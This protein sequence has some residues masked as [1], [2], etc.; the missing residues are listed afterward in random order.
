M[1]AGTLSPT[2]PGN[3]MSTTTVD[4]AATVW[5][6]GTLFALGFASVSYRNDTAGE[7]WNNNTPVTIGAR[8]AKRWNSGVLQAN[9]GVSLVAHSTTG[10]PIAPIGYVSYWA[11][12]RQ[13][14]AGGRWTGLAFPGHVWA[15]SGVMTPLEP[16][17]WLSSGSVEEGVRVWRRGALDFVPYAAVTAVRDTHGYAWD[18]KT[19]VD[20]GGKVQRFIPGGVVEAGVARRDES[21][22]AAGLSRS[23]PAFF[24]NFWIGWDPRRIASKK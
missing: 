8:L 11:G 22:S 12:W 1:S 5:Q 7:P 14:R 13:E 16:H 18:N 2:E 23:G 10:T 17:N 9:V 21:E 15:S 20:I 3:A 4:Q 6:S 24:V 19:T